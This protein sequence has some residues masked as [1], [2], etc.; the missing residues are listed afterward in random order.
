MV[1]WLASEPR[2]A[3]CRA[4]A[5]SYAVTRLLAI[6]AGGAPRASVNPILGWPLSLVKEFGTHHPQN[7]LLLH[8]DYLELKV[9]EKQQMQEGL[10]DLPLFTS[11]RP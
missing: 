2:Q 3:N 6:P 4:Y 1:E 11:N 10:S 5:P 8:P 7:T 9:P